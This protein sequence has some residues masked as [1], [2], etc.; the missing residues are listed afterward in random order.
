VQKQSS[1]G[2]IQEYIQE[3][4]IRQSYSSGRSGNGS[5]EGVA[6]ATFDAACKSLTETRAMAAMT[7]MRDSKRV[8][9]L[10]RLPGACNS[11]NQLS[12]PSDIFDSFA[13]CYN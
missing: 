7:P 10:L 1:D 13:A 4:C 3:S 8:S 12:C 2:Y 11:T 5:L 6:C 9:A